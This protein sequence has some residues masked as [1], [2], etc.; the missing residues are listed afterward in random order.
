MT[1][2]NK[3]FALPVIAAMFAFAG[4]AEVSAQAAPTLSVTA[5][6]QSV[7]GVLRGTSNANFATFRLD[8]TNSGED[9]EISE[10]PINLV[11]GNGASAGDLSDC[12]VYDTRNMSAALNSGTN[13]DAFA[14]GMNTLTLDSTY[15][16]DS[17]TVRTL[18][19]QCDV[20]AS[21]EVGDTYQ[22]NL[23]VS[24]LD[25]VSADSNQTLN[26]GNTTAGSGSIIPVVT[27]LPASTTPAPY[28]PPVVIPTTPGFPSTGMG[29]E[30]AMN[31]ALI[32]LSVLALG[33]VGVRK[34]AK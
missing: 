8:A 34:F 28:I 31:I 17:G 27:V 26:F 23:A 7:I 33:F 4:I 5:Y 9:I 11:L 24:D 15:V 3:L 25:A 16:V 18:Q 21:A 20:S 2:I 13:V 22:F 10:L 29:G 14:S 12:R 30:A 6:T 19:V 32:S 1:K